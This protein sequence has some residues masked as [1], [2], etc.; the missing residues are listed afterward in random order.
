MKKTKNRL[1]TTI[2]FSSLLLFL[3][4]GEVYAVSIHIN[5][6]N[7]GLELEYNLKRWGK[8]D[9]TIAP[10]DPEKQLILKR[11]ARL[12]VQLWIHVDSIDTSKLV[13]VVNAVIKT[14]IMG[15]QKTYPIA[16]PFGD[17]GIEANFFKRT[18]LI[19]HNTPIE[20]SLELGILKT[21]YDIILNLGTQFNKT[22]KGSSTV[23]NNVI[24]E[25][26]PLTVTGNDLGSSIALTILPVKTIPLT[27]FIYSGGVYD[28]NNVLVQ[29]FSGV[30]PFPNGTYKLWLNPGFDFSPQACCLANACGEVPITICTSAGGI[31]Q[32]AGTTC[33]AVDCSDNSTD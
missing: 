13:P 11:M 14:I 23:R 32:G 3:S 1:L 30:L 28:G 26:I 33:A 29:P 6:G 21:D 19:T 8:D 10:G 15:N 4:T 9:V 17:Y 2:F 16:I 20:I 18:Q 31:P 22:Y 12:F 7:T 5:A 24:Q 25:I 27:F